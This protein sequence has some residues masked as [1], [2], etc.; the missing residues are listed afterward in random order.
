MKLYISGPMTGLQHYNRQSFETAAQSL[1]SKGHTV[2]N[3]TELPEPVVPPDASE[4]ISWS[5]YLVRDLAVLNEE[6][7]DCIIL[8]PGWRTSRGACL[9]AHYAKETLG[10]PAKALGEFLAE[11][12]AFPW[13]SK[14]EESNDNPR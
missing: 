13:P 14:K 8:L 9:E 2:V 3:P 12:Y 10:I 5:A 7:P 11:S 1:R 4:A 6:K